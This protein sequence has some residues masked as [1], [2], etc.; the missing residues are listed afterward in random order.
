MLINEEITRY[1]PFCCQLQM[2]N[3]NGMS[4]DMPL[5]RKIFA[6]GK[7]RRDILFHPLTLTSLF[8]IDVAP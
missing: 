3:S 7:I 6:S 5:L 2:K 4:K 1:V 8:A